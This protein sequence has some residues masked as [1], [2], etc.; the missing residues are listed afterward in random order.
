MLM[1]RSFFRDTIVGPNSYSVVRAVGAIL[2]I[3]CIA[4]ILWNILRII[5]S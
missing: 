3:D 2:F 4:E 5:R 1:M